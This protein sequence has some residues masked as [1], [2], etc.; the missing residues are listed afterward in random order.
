MGTTCTTLG[1]N[2]QCS[3]NLCDE[4]EVPPLI[5]EEAKSD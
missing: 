4:K 3:N 5:K 2:N 1:Y